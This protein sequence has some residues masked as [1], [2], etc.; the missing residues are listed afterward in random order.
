MKTALILGCLGQDGTLLASYL[1]NTGYRVCGLSRHSPPLPLAGTL[2]NMEIFHGDMRDGLSI[3]SA[4]WNS[5]PDEVY[6]LAGQVFVPVSWSRP[7]ETFEVNVGGLGR[8]LE[9][10]SRIKPNTRVYQASSS[11][12]Y[13]NQDGACDETRPFHPTSPYGISKLA[14]H[15]MVQIYRAKG[16]FV[17]GGIL[18]NH[19]SMYRTP[20]MVTRKITRAVAAWKLGSTEKLMLG[21][22]ESK[23]DWGY[24]G[25]YVKAMHKMLQQDQPKDY[26]IGTGTSRS[27]REFL[28]TALRESGIRAHEME[29]YEREMV[30]TQPSLHRDNEIKELCAN[31]RLAWKDLQWEPRTGFELWVREMVEHDIQLMSGAQHVTTA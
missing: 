24:A 6:N 23:R 21:N 20:A 28:R 19:E 14:A 12:M 26:V 17:V 5:W 16:M 30:A 3:E 27:V 8:L 13:G 25:D 1:L 18:F 22:L 15:E 9:A 10:L 31:S 7:N 29:R 11:E 2:G 4:I